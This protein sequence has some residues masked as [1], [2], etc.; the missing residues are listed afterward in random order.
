MSF[1]SPFLMLLFNQLFTAFTLSYLN[2][3]I[4][5]VVKLDTS[6]NA[7]CF[8]LQPSGN[9]V[10]SKNLLAIRMTVQSQSTNRYTAPENS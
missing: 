9:P 2:K 4:N 8:I 10:F 3:Q 7:T 5:K 6:S 1:I